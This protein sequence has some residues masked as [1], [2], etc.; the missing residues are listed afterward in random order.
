MQR[1]REL[2]LWDMLRAGQSIER[3]LRGRTLSEYKANDLLRSA[4]ER[5]FEVLGEAVNQACA[6]YPELSEEI[7]L[8]RNVVA[9]RNQLSHGY[10]NLDDEIVWS[11]AERYLPAFLDQV[12]AL[13]QKTGAVDR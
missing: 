12:H 4:V 8:H 2:Y 3:F 5:K 13:L 11:I 7:D 10:F 1:E 9:F 6:L